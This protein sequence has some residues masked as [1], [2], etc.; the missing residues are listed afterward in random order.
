MADILD[1][2]TGKQGFFFVCVCG[3]TEAR[4]LRKL[5]Y[6]DVNEALQRATT[7]L[8]CKIRQNRHIIPQMANI[9]FSGRDKVY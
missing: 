3:I 5:L 6:R 8:W 9:V 1:D 4:V 7:V 2:V